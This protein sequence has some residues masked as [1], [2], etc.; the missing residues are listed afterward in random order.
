MSTHPEPKNE[1]SFR[2][3]Y[4]E[5]E[6]ILNRLR[7][8]DPALKELTLDMSRLSSE[9]VRQLILQSFQAVATNTSL[10]VLTIEDDG[11]FFY[12][13]AFSAL[14]LNT[15]LKDIRMATCGI[16]MQITFTIAMCSPNL[17]ALTMRFTNHWAR[18]SPDY[19]TAITQ[20]L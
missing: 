6:R 2:L 4:E 9:Y 12:D 17:E 18:P 8:D 13:H 1:I 16:I 14:S 11:A 5:N 20:V 10:E 3:P 7:R 19:L 15:S